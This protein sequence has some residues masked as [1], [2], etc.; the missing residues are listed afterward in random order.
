MELLMGLVLF[1]AM[2]FVLHIVLAVVSWRAYGGVQV[3]AQG[4]CALLWMQ[5]LHAAAQPGY[6]EGPAGA[7]GL[8]LFVYGWFAMTV[9]AVVA[10]VLV[11]LFARAKRTAETH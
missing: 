9:A 2:V 8:M 3:L 7:L 4:G 1:A 5:H 11:A 6:N 10:G